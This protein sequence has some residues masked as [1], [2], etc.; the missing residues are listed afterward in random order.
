MRNCN[1]R[2][3]RLE[4]KLTQTALAK[5]AG[6]SRQTINCIEHGKQKDI[7]SDTLFAIANAL[8]VPVGRIFLD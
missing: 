4:K 2:A 5:A 3:I 6:V 8:E 7:K 1:L